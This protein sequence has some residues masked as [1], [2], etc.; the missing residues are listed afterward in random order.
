MRKLIKLMAIVIC[1]IVPTVLLNQEAETIKPE[2]E[3][4]DQINLPDQELSQEESLTSQDLSGRIIRDI[5]VT[6]NTQVNTAAVLTKLPYRKGQIFDPI[7]S[8]EAIRN[9]YFDL[10]R[11]RNISIMADP[12]D[13]N[14]ID[15]HII[16]EE[17]IP[18]GEIVFEGNSA[19]S[20]KD[21]KE[22]IPQLDVQAIDQEELKPF[23]QA[24]KK[25][26]YR[27]RLL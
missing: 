24:I 17:K 6:G 23:A 27:T 4:I 10:K 8:R 20:E 18:V 11:F 21:L 15:L 3:D 1:L 7:K 14:T 25:T 22:K 9:L 26:V 5:I 13:E 16:V 12:I 2:L 19:I